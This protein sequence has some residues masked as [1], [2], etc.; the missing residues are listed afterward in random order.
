MSDRKSGAVFHK[1]LIRS[2]VRVF[3]EVAIYFNGDFI[4]REIENMRTTIALGIAILP[5][6]ELEKRQGAF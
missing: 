1:H 5:S 4:N 6:T 2:G 3:G